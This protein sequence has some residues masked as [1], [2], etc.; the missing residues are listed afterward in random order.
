MIAMEADTRTETDNPQIL[1]SRVVRTAVYNR[2]GALLGHVD[3]LS[4]EKQTGRVI[5][6]IMSF[7]GFLRIGERFHPIPWSLLD[8]DPGLDGFVVDLG[9]EALRGAPHYD[10]EELRA[11]G[12]ADHRRFGEHIQGY[13]GRD[14]A[15]RYW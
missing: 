11:L 1:S 12:G 13:Y 6:A 2:D 14:S 10:R 15:A 5:Y 9:A 8:F 3:D 7:G 4:I